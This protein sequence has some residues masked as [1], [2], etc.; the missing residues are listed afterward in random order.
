MHLFNMTNTDI[1]LALNWVDEVIRIKGLLNYRNYGYYLS[2]LGYDNGKR[3]LPFLYKQKEDYEKK[4]AQASF[5][6][7][8]QNQTLNIENINYIIDSIET[9]KP[10]K[11]Y[12]F[13]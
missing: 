9:G 2:K 12:V 7:Q 13:D 10:S 11:K 6:Y 1:P 4:L 8:I 5:K 3:F